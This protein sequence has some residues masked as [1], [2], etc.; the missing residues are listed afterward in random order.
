MESNKSIFPFSNIL[1]INPDAEKIAKNK[2]P[3]NN[4]ATTNILNI[5][6]ISFEI[7]ITALLLVLIIPVKSSKGTNAKIPAK[8]NI[9]NVD[10]A[11]NAII[12]FFDSASLTV[13]SAIVKIF[14]IFI[15]LLFVNIFNYSLH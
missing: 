11:K 3:P 10:I 8:S 7:L 5:L 2:P 1:G 6:T 14:F 9:T 13:N 4:G 15:I 12:I